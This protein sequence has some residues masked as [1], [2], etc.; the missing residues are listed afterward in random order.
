MIWQVY[1]EGTASSSS[2]SGNK[3]SCTWCFGWSQ[4]DDP[5]GFSYGSKPITGHQH[6]WPRLLWRHF[7]RESR[8]LAFSR[9][10]DVR[11]LKVRPRGSVAL[12]GWVNGKPLPWWNLFFFWSVHNRIYLNMDVWAQSARNTLRGWK[13]KRVRMN[14]IQTSRDGLNQQGM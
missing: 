4:V 12:W 14:R 5:N 1:S 13:Q 8:H 7:P 9:P 11:S 10:A 3:Q 2:L 6:S